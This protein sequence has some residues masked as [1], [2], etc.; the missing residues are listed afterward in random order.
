MEC[1][2]CF[3]ISFLEATCNPIWENAVESNRR[4]LLRSLGPSKRIMVIWQSIPYSIKVQVY[5]SNLV[6]T[7]TQGMVGSGRASVAAVADLSRAFVDDMGQNAPLPVRA[8]ASLGAWGSHT[9]NQERELHRWTK[10]LYDLKLNTLFG[11]TFRWGWN[12]LCMYGL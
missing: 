10:H 7:G 3:S 1:K 4:I 6:L 2:T 12:R 9:Q 8:M 11:L 5:S